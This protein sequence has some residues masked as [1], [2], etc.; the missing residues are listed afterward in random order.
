MAP[1]D[2]CL[3][4]GRLKKIEP[5]V[6]LVARELQTAKEEMERARTSCASGNWNDTAMQSYFVLTRCARAA[7]HARGYKD[8]NLYGLQVALEHLFIEPGE[9]DRAITRQIRD[10]KD[11]KDA[12]YNGRRASP[13]EARTMLGAAQEFARFVFTRLALPGFSG[14]DVP[15]NIPEPA[16][17]RADAGAAAQDR[18]PLGPAQRPPRPARGPY[19]SRGDRWNREERPRPA[20]YARQSSHSRPA[21]E[22]PLPEGEGESELEVQ[23]DHSRQ[24]D[25]IRASTRPRLP[26][27]DRRSEQP[28]RPRRTPRT[29][30][31]GQAGNA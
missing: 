4:K 23:P 7:I 19:P 18:Q 17:A 25:W 11:V 24:I 28:S 20:G 30:D 12:V 16:N 8:T 2:D 26:F 31:E 29:D 5:D 13:Y 10:A 1:F 22:E 27:W 21:P 15:T 9:L 3:T 14:D 6:N